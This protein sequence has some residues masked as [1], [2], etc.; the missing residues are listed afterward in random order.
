MVNIKMTLAYDGRAYLGW[1]KTKEGPSIEESLQSVL[2]K[3][4]QQPISLQAASRTDAGV[5]AVGQV[6]NFQIASWPGERL[7]HSANCL[8][9]AEIRLLHVEAAHEAFHP[10]LDVKEK[11][12]HY[13]ICNSPVQLPQHRFNSWHLHMPLDL[14]QMEKAA[15]LLRGRHDFAAF[16]NALKECDYENTMREITALTLTP[17]PEQRLRVAVRGP[18]FLYRM[19]RNLVG[20]LV[21]VGRGKITLDVLRSLL[22]S[23]DRTKAGLTA[24]PHGLTLFKV[25]YGSTDKPIHECDA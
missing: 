16:C 24:P 10:T 20:T 5:H 2:E 12:Y 7:R 18:H 4:L 13:W 23:G 15:Q 8:L 14:N 3:I 17:Y 19:V 11:E 9:P 1:Q 6:V 25:E 22:T 21:E